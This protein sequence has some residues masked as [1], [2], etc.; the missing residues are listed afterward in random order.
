MRLLLIRH[1]QTPANVR[2][3]LDTA[4]PGPGLT[5]RGRAQAASIPSAL[6]GLPIDAIYVSSLVRT[7]LTAA[8]LAAARDLDVTVLGGVHEIE[9][10]SLE[11]ATDHV[12]YRSYLETCM[13]WGLGQRERMM[14]GAADGTAFF[15]RFDASIAQLTAMDTA[16]V[17]SHGAAMRV[18]VAGTARGIDPMLTAKQE[19]DNTGLVEL[20]GSPAAGWELVRWQGEPLGGGILGDPSA[21][22]PTGERI[23]EALA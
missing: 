9:A 18:W 1:G 23:D 20:H 4:A 17:F 6:D 5:A 15:N 16:V 19:L 14:P 12:S 3:E 10:G 22:D 21:E 13:A 2:G 8:P 7:Q 11:M